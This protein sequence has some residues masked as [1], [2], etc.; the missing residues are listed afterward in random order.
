LTSCI[1]KVFE[2]VVLNRLVDN[3]ERQGLLEEEQAG[4]WAGRSTRDQT[5]ILRELLDSRKAAGK[6]TFLCFVDLTNAFPSSWQDGM[7]FRLREA[8]VGGKLFRSIRAMYRA[9]S[10][11]I[12]TPFGLTDWYTSDL[13]TRQGAVMS[14]FLFSLLISPLARVLRAAGLGVK[15]GMD[16]QIACLLYADDLVLIAESKE[17][18]EKMM[19]ETTN[20]LRKWRFSV[21]VGKTQVFACGKSE[22]RGLKDRIWQ[23]GGVT[24]RDVRSYKYLGLHFEKNGLWSKMHDT[25]IENSN[26][27]YCPLYQIGFAEAGLHIGQSAFL[28]NSF[29]RPRLLYGAEVW[30]VNSETNW[31]DLEKAQL[32]AA[33]RIFG[34]QAAATVIGEALRGDLGWLSVKSLIALAK[35]KFFGHLCHLPTDRLLKK[36]FLYRKDQYQHTCQALHLDKV[37]DGS[38]YSEICNILA[39]LGLH[40][41]EWSV[42]GIGRMSKQEW[43]SR[44]EKLVTS[45]DSRNLFAGFPRTSSSLHYSHIKRSPGQE[46]Y[47]WRHN[48]RSAT[49]KFA[50]RSRSYCLQARFHQKAGRDSVDKVCILCTSGEEETEEH[51]L[52][53]W[54]L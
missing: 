54:S 33:K 8:G 17:A 7:W 44:I 50:L 36:V 28:W 52:L 51:H 37:S 21:S 5:F 29:A 23:I 41:D 40:A 3:C 39:T 22:T 4:F 9:C 18:M 12:Q 16:S 19:Q 47:I 1:S 48:R 38:W 45:M 27:A 14:P 20:F 25:V 43:A 31:H 34:K 10:S 35:L 15:F 53:R 30:S 42:E 2:R 13:G 24:I 11:A 26:N 32:Q 49:I 6:T 46:D